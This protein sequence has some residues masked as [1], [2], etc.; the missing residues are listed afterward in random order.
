M[1]IFRQLEEIGSLPGVK[2]ASIGNFD[3][4]HCAHQYVLREI[5]RRAKEMNG[6]SIAITFD[7]HPTRILRPDRTPKLITT[8]E[9]KLAFIAEAGVDA[10]LVLPF[11]AEFAQ[12][13]AREFCRLLCEKGRVREI[14]E[15]KNF[16]FGRGAEADASRM[17]ELGREIGFQVVIYPEQWILGEPVS[18]SRIRGLISEGRINLARHLLGRP[19]FIRSNPAP[20]RGYGMQY[21]VPT[22]NLASY[23]ELLPANGVY[24]TDLE[25]NGR[26]WKSV[27][28]IGTRPTFGV[29][30]FAVE[31]HILEFE[32]MPLGEKTP[33][34][35]TFL[36]RLRE[37]RRWPTP[38]ALKAQIGKDIARARRWFE[39]AQ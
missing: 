13:S 2:V 36:H 16:R 17:Q 7:P 1:K 3:G 28:N 4:V 26:S 27:S 35:L 21:T 33:L 39:L 15:G 34:K 23:S 20:G 25:V 22:I 32:Q 6:H 10:T 31:T 30:S 24:V 5:V 8:L 18:S 14:H 29:D 9:D 11:T 19:F 37:E 38:E 12:T